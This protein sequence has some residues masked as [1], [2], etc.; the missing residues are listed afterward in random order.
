MGRP[1]ISLFTLLLL[2]AVGCVDATLVWASVGGP[3]ETTPRR[4]AAAGALLMFNLLALALHRRVVV[5]RGRGFR[6][7]FLAGGVAA[8]VAFMLAVVLLPSSP[9]VDLAGMVEAICWSALWR[10]NSNYAWGVTDS[11]TPDALIPVQLMF[12]PAV[13]SALALPQLIIAVLGGV[14][15]RRM[16]RARS[17]SAPGAGD[18]ETS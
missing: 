6:T 4:V 10:V 13:A 11:G 1:R 18:H 14:V 16:A 3:A 8:L 2:I 9:F 7:G 5:G 15:G 12:L 17:V